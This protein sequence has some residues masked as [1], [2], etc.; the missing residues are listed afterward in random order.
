MCFFQ[1]SNV[2]TCYEYINEHHWTTSSWNTFPPSQHD[3]TC[4]FPVYSVWRLKLDIRFKNTHGGASSVV[5]WIKLPL[6]IPHSLSECLGWNPSSSLLY[7]ASCYCTWGQMIAH[8]G[9]LGGFRVAWLSPGLLY[10]FGECASA[11]VDRKSLWPPPHLIPQP[12]TLPFKWK[13]F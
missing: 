8:M 10:A 5:Q 6:G 12:P 1:W 9:D 4:E 7:L 2:D 13:F 3:W 11:S